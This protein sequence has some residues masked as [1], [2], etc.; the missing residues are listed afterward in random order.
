MT[1]FDLRGRITESGQL[2][3]ELPEGLP[4]G[5]VRIRIEL[6][7]GSDISPLTDDDIT[8]LMQ[9][10]PMT[11]AEIVAAGL[12]GGWRDLDISDG[13]AWVEDVRR[14]RKERRSW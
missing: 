14:K 2:E 5:E 6:A 10:T 13:T 11:G 3:V 9:T 8:R 7:E 12:T 4:S 1:V